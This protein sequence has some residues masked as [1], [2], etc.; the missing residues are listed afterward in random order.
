MVSTSEGLK[1]R[2][3]A[4]T[5]PFHP[6]HRSAQTG[7]QEETTSSIH[8]VKIVREVPPISH[9]VFDDNAMFFL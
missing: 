8:G 7:L 4:L 1:T 5:F 9:L 2:Q 3:P 6:C